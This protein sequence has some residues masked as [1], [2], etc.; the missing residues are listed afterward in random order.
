VKSYIANNA[1][2]RIFEPG[3]EAPGV[4]RTT[5]L[6]AVVLTVAVISLACVSFMPSV[7]DFM[8]G[9][10]LWNGLAGFSEQ[11]SA[12]NLE[13]PAQPSGESGATVL[14]IPQLPLSPAE[15]SHLKDFAANGGTLAIADDYG[16]GNQVLEY[17]GLTARFSQLTLM[18]PFFCYKN[19][20][21]P[22][23]TDFS[24]EVAQYGVVSIV[25]NN[26]TVLTGVSPGDVLAWSSAESFL[27]SGQTPAS[28]PVATGPFPIAARIKFGSGNIVLLS[29]PSIFINSMLNLEDN[30][31]FLEYLLGKA[32]H[33][34][35]LYVIE[36]AL[37]RGAMDYAKRGLARVQEAF[38]QPMVAAVFLAAIFAIVF[39]FSFRTKN[40]NA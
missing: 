22:R 5:V 12:V 8:F 25:L 15:L 13:S 23:I 28:T 7:N 38:R 24:P 10:T 20:A 16:H 26:A 21:L 32:A 17:L 27:G 34:G 18:D 31:L 11:Y 2:P 1:G 40:G 19:P 36:S 30:R 9:N 4:D 6:L 3:G 37:D 14:L 33:A 35:G 29:D 39:H